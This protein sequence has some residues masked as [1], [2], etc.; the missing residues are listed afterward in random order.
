MPAMQPGQ[1]RKDVQGP[2]RLCFNCFEPGHFA[3]K[4]PKPRRQQGQAPPCSNNGGKDVIR[5]RVNQVT[6]EDVL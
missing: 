4:C 3:D 2:Q 5:G 6:A 1:G